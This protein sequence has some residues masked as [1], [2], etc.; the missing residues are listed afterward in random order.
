MGNGDASQLEMYR[1]ITLST[2]V[3]CLKSKLFEFVLVVLFGDSLQS[4]NLQFSFKRNSS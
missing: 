3:L 2:Q 4:S 1:G